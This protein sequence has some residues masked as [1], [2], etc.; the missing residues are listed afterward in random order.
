MADITLKAVTDLLLEPSKAS[1]TRYEKAIAAVIHSAKIPGKVNIPVDPKFTFRNKSQAVAALQKEIA[2]VESQIPI[3]DS[4]A[5]DLSDKDTKKYLST[6]SFMKDLESLV[7]SRPSLSNAQI[8]RGEKLI[9]EIEAGN[10]D[11]ASLR[12]DQQKLVKNVVAQR[13]ASAKQLNQLISRS[14][15][16]T[17]EYSV[18]Q[19]QLRNLRESYENQTRA[20]KKLTDDTYLRAEASKKEKFLLDQREKSQKRLNQAEAKR[21]AEIEKA[22]STRASQVAKTK[23]TDYDRALR[24]AGV[25]PIS[26]ENK[27]KEIDRGFRQMDALR[28]KERQD[29][30]RRARAEVKAHEARIAAE[31]KRRVIA[32]RDARQKRKEYNDF[33]KRTSENARFEEGRRQYQAH[34]GAGSVNDIDRNNA[35]VVKD[36]LKE[37]KKLEELNL[38]RLLSVGAPEKEITASKEKIRKLADDYDYLGRKI[39]GS[40]AALREFSLLFRQFLR[41]AVGFTVLYGIINAVGSLARNLIDLQDSLKK[42]QAVTRTTDRAINSVGFT[43]L[44]TALRTRFGINDIADATQTL[45][46]AGIEVGNI[47]KALKA[48]ADFAAATNTEL[49]TSADL[50][51]TLSN[52]FPEQKYSDLANQI[53]RVVNIS[54][55]ASEDLKVIL[56]YSAQAAASYNIPVEQYL[57]SIATLRNQ[58]FRQSTI[59]TGLRRVYSDLFNPKDTTLR[60]FQERY[61]EIGENMELDEIRQ[62]FFSFSNEADPLLAALS[63]LERLGFTGPGQV[64]LARAF[65]IRSLNAIRGLVRGLDEYAESQAKVASGNAALEGSR[66]AME[67]LRASLDNLSESFTSLASSVLGGGIDPLE[68]MVDRVVDL[69]EGLAEANERRKALYGTSGIASVGAFGA[70]AVTGFLSSR[71]NLAQRGIAGLMSG[72]AGAYLSTSQVSEDATSEQNQMRQVATGVAAGLFPAVLGKLFDFLRRDKS[73]KLA[74][75]NATLLGRFTSTIVGLLSSLGSAVSK[76]SLLSLFTGPLGVARFINPI[77]GL[78]TTIGA[79]AFAISKARTKET[80]ESIQAR[81]EASLNTLDSKIIERDEV[82]QELSQY[83][84]SGGDYTAQQGTS[85]GQAE[86]IQVGMNDLRVQIRDFFG[87]EIQ[88]IESTLNALDRLSK[89][90]GVQGTPTQDRLLK[91]LAETVKVIGPDGELQEVT[92]GYLRGQFEGLFE[93]A[94]ETSRLLSGAEGLRES[95]VE[96]FQ[97]LYDRDLAELSDTER[98]LRDRIDDSSPDTQRILLGLDSSVK[99]ERFIQILLDLY[100]DTSEQV[101]GALED[102]TLDEQENRAIDLILSGAET[103]KIRVALDELVEKAISLGGTVEGY[104]SGLSKKIEEAEQ[105]LQARQAYARLGNNTFMGRIRSRFGFGREESNPEAQQAINTAQQAIVDLNAREVEER[106]KAN[107]KVMADAEGLI[108]DIR[109]T[110]GPDSEVADFI[111]DLPKGNSRRTM[112]ENVLAGSTSAGDLY[113]TDSSGNLTLNS[114]A[115]RLRR[116]QQ[117]ALERIP[118]ERETKIRPFRENYATEER[119]DQVSYQLTEAE[120]TNA[121]LAQKESLLREQR[122]LKLSQVNDQIAYQ[123]YL[124]SQDSEK[125]EEVGNEINKLQFEQRKIQM[126]YNRSLTELARQAERQALDNRSTVLDYQISDMANDLNE[127]VNLGGLEVDQIQGLLDAQDERREL[128][129]ERLEV[130]RRSLELESTASE[131]LE[132]RLAQLKDSLKDPIDPRTAGNIVQS[133]ESVKNLQYVQALPSAQSSVIGVQNYESGESSRVQ[134]TRYSSG[135]FS[136]DDRVSA[137]VA[138]Q[139]AISTAIEDIKRATDLLGLQG[140][141][142]EEQIR[143][144]QKLQIELGELDAAREDMTQGFRGQLGD[145]FDLRTLQ[146]G[147]ETASNSIENLDNDIQNKLISSIDQMGA[148]LTEAFFSGGDAAKNLKGILA[149]LFNYIS[150]RIGAALFSEA[151]I[152]IM[153]SMGGGGAGFASGIFQKAFGT[154]GAATGAYLSSTGMVRGPSRQQVDSVPATVFSRGGKPLYDVAITEGEAVLNT[155]AVK[156]LGGANAIHKINSG[157]IKMATGGVLGGGQVSFSPNVSSPTVNPVFDPQ[158]VLANFSERQDFE[159]FLKSPQ[160]RKAMINYMSHDS[161]QVKK[162]LRLKD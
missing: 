74:A 94:N 101:L 102:F 92:E 57:A 7:N 108:S 76:I 110:F 39:S 117:D 3:G 40:G 12:K 135:Q 61:Q 60:A 75:K 53:A 17:K 31:E 114:N 1:V 150:Q 153:G 71:G 41:L 143:L 13:E 121:S 127:L 125:S 28:E 95:V 9:G 33:V 19:P 27:N 16:L 148:S 55:L 56:N 151:I 43:I 154:P 66:T 83:R 44:R 70:G 85:V 81:L 69:N 119:L 42:I 48:T 129:N 131:V 67:S 116:L 52:V 147:L 11:F 37:A 139:E 103:N 54:K 160:G 91:A 162:S 123:S 58:G 106:K 109:A 25:S 128:V 90:G 32:E 46:Q 51:T 82:I 112:V 14:E 107:Q 26:T 122:N 80:P 72:S 8:K 77:V 149:D 136:R 5:F 2:R 111:T 86:S 161:A 145:A 115:D 63:E 59:G 124:L 49:Q 21:A 133:L 157:A 79:I 138:R 29:V 35:R 23:D 98:A 87:G 15:N 45:V 62:R 20:V 38:N 22:F 130:E 137:L 93:V 34:G 4:G 159:A 10:T 89:E 96:T 140:P 126:E 144:V 134:A 24:Q 78:V 158:I 146:T 97:L 152:G 105:Q 99:P 142:L 68:D 132:V 118:E 18:T 141:A 47:P 65:D 84:P 64:T 36:Y 50:M 104:T 100:S 120:R 73:V 6:I 88:N 155:A 30:Q 113:S 156:R